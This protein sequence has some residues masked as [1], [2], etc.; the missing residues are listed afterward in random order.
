MLSQ[1][2]YEIKSA[3]ED[4]PQRMR[5]LLVGR[6]EVVRTVNG[7]A[8]PLRR[9][10]STV[11]PAFYASDREAREAIVC[12]IEKDRAAHSPKMPN[13]CTRL[14]LTFVTDQSTYIEVG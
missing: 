8:A 5:A 10:G 7:E 4:A 9:A 11:C 1:I 14:G 2:T 3:G 13:G 12:A 6:R